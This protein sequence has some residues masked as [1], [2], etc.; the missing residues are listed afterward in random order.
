M[1]KI[2]V[3]KTLHAS[4]SA[5][6]VLVL[7][8]TSLPLTSMNTSAET[9]SQTKYDNITDFQK[10]RWTQ[11]QNA[12]FGQN[13]DTVQDTSVIDKL[14]VQSG[15]EFFNWTD[16]SKIKYTY[17]YKDANGVEHAEE[18]TGLKPYGT[19][20]VTSM[21]HFDVHES[22]FQTFT[23]YNGEK[24]PISVFWKSYLAYNVYTADQFAYLANYAANNS[25]SI[26]IVLQADIDMGGAEGKEFTTGKEL[27]SHLCIEGN[28]HTIYNWK[29]SGSSRYFGLFCS[30]Q[31]S[32]GTL[33]VKNLGVQSAMLLHHNDTNDSGAGLFFGGGWNNGGYCLIMCI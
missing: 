21:E 7:L 31:Y 28:G 30:V 27:Q 33:I 12:V 14:S 18:I 13:F 1:T 11:I 25:K 15:N 3:N 26:K 5:L 16:T 6:L 29:M 23:K 10:A 32:V 2:K 9:A 17:K 22:Y 8:V 24:V 19:D 4:L 20:T